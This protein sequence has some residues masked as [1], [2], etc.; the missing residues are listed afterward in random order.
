MKEDMT[1]AE[2]LAALIDDDDDVEFY[3]DAEE[4]AEPEPEEMCE[5]A[6]M[7]GVMSDM[8]V[9]NDPRDMV[10]RIIANPPA[11]IIF[12]KNGDKTVVRCSPDD[13]YDIEKGIAVAFMKYMF[14]NG[15]K[16][17]ELFHDL[18]GETGVVY[19]N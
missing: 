3:E 16:F 9:L 11:T 15:G 6:P 8:G 1:L 18:K 17:N 12:W 7:A 13:K 10:D 4:D 19:G 2:F 14:G 5:D